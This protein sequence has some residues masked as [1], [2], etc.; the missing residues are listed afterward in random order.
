MKS[1]EAIAKVIKEKKAL[2]FSTAPFRKLK[3]RKYNDSYIV[4]MTS[5]AGRF[6]S[7]G[8]FFRNFENQKLLPKRLILYLTE[9][10]SKMLIEREVYLPKF[11]NIRLCEDLGPGKKLIPALREFSTK[12]LITIDD[13]VIYPID[14]IERL[15]AYSKDFPRNII[16]G[17]T[18]YVTLDDNLKPRK[19]AEWDQNVQ[20]Y[21]QS[22][23]LL[24]PTGVGMVLYPPNSLHHDVLDVETY[25]ENCLF[26]DDI[27]F[28]IQ[29]IRA[30]TEVR[31]L[32]GD[33]Q[34]EYLPKTQLNGLWESK[35]SK[36]GN[37]SALELLL[38]RYGD[39]EFS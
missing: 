32:P 31:L 5:H 25:L 4:T 22:S 2:H 10:D 13:D 21:N 37:D 36:G 35:N 23:R 33:N 7:L 30:G 16:A 20:I 3:Q 9:T 18:H 14:L 8:D 24:F 34:F 38:K 1:M 39:L 6:H 28:Y 29:A 26:Q 11:V 15:I 12:I 17:R 27:W 19:Y